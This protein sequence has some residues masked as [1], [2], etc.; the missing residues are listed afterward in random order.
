MRI[1]N[2][3]KSTLTIPLSGNQR[4]SIPPH[5]V[6]GDFMPNKDFLSL[7]VTTFDYNEISLI[8]SGPY[9]ISMCSQV[10]GCTGFVSQSL[11]EAIAKFPEEKKPEPKPTIKPEVLEAAAKT[12]KEEAVEEKVV[13]ETTNNAPETSADKAEEKEEEKPVKVKRRRVTKKKDKD[14]SEEE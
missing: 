5:S 9:E 6:S 10:S 12:A 2:G 13:E 14:S 8:V 11:E 4:L 1:Y 7:M 3:K